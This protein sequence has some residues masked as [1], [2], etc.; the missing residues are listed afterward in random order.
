MTW[1]SVRRFASTLARVAV[2]L[3]SFWSFSTFLPRAPLQDRVWWMVVASFVLA[4]AIAWASMRAASVMKTRTVVRSLGVAGWLVLCLSARSV[5]VAQVVIDFLL[6]C[7][8][9]LALCYWSPLGANGNRVAAMAH[10]QARRAPLVVL[11]ACL[12]MVF[13]ACHETMPWSVSAFVL[14]LAIIQ[15]AGASFPDS[16]PPVPEPDDLAAMPTSTRPA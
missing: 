13:L 15:A 16:V 3:A 10:Y 12:T 14:A 8:P 2:L 6:L 1:S 4:Q 11:A 9:M 7:G 5:G